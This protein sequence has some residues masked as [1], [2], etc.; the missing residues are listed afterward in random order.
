MGTTTETSGD[1]TLVGGSG[2]DLLSGGDGNDYLNGG[3]GN[4]TLDG[5]SGSDTVMGGSGADILIF[6]AYENVGTST[7]AT[8][9][10]GDKYNGGSGAMKPTSPEY[11]TLEIWLSDAQL[12]DA[13]VIQQILD[14]QAW[15]KLQFNKSTGQAGTAVFDFTT[16]NL[17]ASQIEKLILKDEDGNVIINS[18]GTVVTNP[19]VTSVVLN[20]NNHIITDADVGLQVTATITFSQAMDTSTAPLVAT[21]GTLCVVPGSG[22]W[23]D[24]THYVV[25]YNVVDTNIELPDLTFN[26][27]GAKGLLGTT[28]NPATGVSTGTAVDTTADV[29]ND[30]ALTIAPANLVTSNAEKTAVGFTVAGLDA[31][32][33]GSVTF[34]DGTHTVVVAVSG[35]GS[36][37]ADLSGLADGPISSV[38]NVTDDAGNTASDAGASIDLDTTITTPTLNITDTTINQSEAGAVAFTVTGVD[39]DV[40]GAD[41]KVTFTGVGTD[42][43]PKVMTVLASAA[44]ADLSGFQD[45]TITTAVTVTDDAGNT[46]TVAGASISLDATAPSFTSGSSASAIAENS[47]ASQVVYTATATDAGAVTY[48][49]KSGGDAG[50][51]TINA[52]T[53]AVTLTG[54]PDFETK[55]SYGFTVIATDAAGNATEQA[56]SLVINN[57]DEVA[58]TIT[59][60]AT[61]AAID[62]NS[63]VGQVVYT[64]TSDDSGDISGGVTYGLGAGGDEGAFSINP[65]TGAVTLTGNPDYEGQS[66]YSFTV[67]ATDA[68]GNHS[69]QAVS[70]AINN[71]NE[72]PT[73]SATNSVTTNE[74][75]ASVAIAMG[76]TDV[77]GDTLTY[78][79]KPGSGPAHGGI[80]FN[81]VNGTFV[82]TPVGNYAGSDTFIIV[83][84]DGQGGTVEQVVGVTVNPVNDAPVATAVTLTAIAEDSGPRL[85]TSAE[86]LAGVT[87]IDGPSPTITALSIAPGSGGTL[88]SNGNG[89]WTYTPA[90]DDDSSVTFNYTASDGSLMS[91]STATMDITP[92]ADFVYVSPPVYTGADPNDFDALGDPAGENL[93]GSGTNGNDTIFGGAGADIINGNGGDDTIYGGSGAD[94]LSGNNDG[95][96]LYGGSGNDAIVGGNNNDRLIGGYGADTLTGSNGADTFVYLSNRDTGD[97]ITDFTQGSDLVDLAAFAP[98][99]FVGV[100][101]QAGAVGPNQVGYMIGGGVT[102]IY[103]DTDGVYGADLEIKLTGSINLTGGDFILGAP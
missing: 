33:S 73:A 9:S 24:A 42:G 31:D 21:N 15:L 61:A 65:T 97:T 94:D 19:N 45:G 6:R 68:A 39:G 95:D 47:G 89:T 36:Y 83:I 76:A 53:G 103:V 4:D 35:N 32:A 55:S 10:G 38:L 16:L 3:S 84:S 34:S 81:Q 23:V 92:V 90:L 27:S 82:Y 96:K 98:S 37:T 25:T 26:V 51:F 100:L 67:V 48:S 2:A 88:V 77:D 14:Y 43:N 72:A 5:G 60:A 1:D 7:D 64:V 57:L 71:V 80:I 93:S 91:S 63:G 49:L 69:E 11:D 30:L 12:Q 41:A 66:S 8:F 50:A 102:T 70:L 74:D 40:L 18:A 75:T 28:Q 86:L 52:S 62:E 17:Q 46:K 87:D 85:I 59:S 13:A 79:I 56:V 44:T 29:G 101:T 20:D 78:S 22:H 99:S 58:P 54:N